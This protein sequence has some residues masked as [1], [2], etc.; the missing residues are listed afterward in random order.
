MASPAVAARLNVS[1]GA[2]VQSVVSGGAAEK[3]GLLPTRRGL[4]GI[5]TGDVIV[6][7]CVCDLLID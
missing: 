5:I 4:A 2:L 1:S 3:A 7:V 6:K